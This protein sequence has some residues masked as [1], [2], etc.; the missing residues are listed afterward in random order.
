MHQKAVKA[1]KLAGIRGRIGMMDLE[2]GE[3]GR[4]VDLALRGRARRGSRL[5]LLRMSLAEETF[6]E[7]QCIV[8]SVRS[9]SFWVARWE[10]VIL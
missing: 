5:Q 7:R 9:E 2:E 6:S 8:L 1:L 3:V 10:E 4:R